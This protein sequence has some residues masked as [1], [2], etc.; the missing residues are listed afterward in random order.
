MSRCGQV[1]TDRLAVV[2]EPAIHF[3]TSSRLPSLLGSVQGNESHW[4]LLQS[5][6]EMPGLRQALLSAQ[7]RI[8]HAFILST[9]RW[10]NAP[11]PI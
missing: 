3:N 2:S 11:S 4:K 9:Y 7:E 6:R 5:E 1:Q 8:P 10:R